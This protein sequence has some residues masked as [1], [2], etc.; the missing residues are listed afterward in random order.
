MKYQYHSM[1]TSS[2]ELLMDDTPRFPLGPHTES[3]EINASPWLAG[4]LSLRLVVIELE[5]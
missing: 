2:D 3:G 4:F 1:D 5:I